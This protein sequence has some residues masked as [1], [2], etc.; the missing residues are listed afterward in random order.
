MTKELNFK[1]LNGNLLIVV[2]EVSNTT[3]SGLIKSETMI[4]EEEKKLDVYVSVAAIS[5][6]VKT[7]KVGD[8]VLLS[9]S[10]IKTIVIDEIR[11]GIVHIT[12]V[13]GIKY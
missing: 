3:K 4:K 6:E 5:D 13:A 8:K 11:Y 9:V 7:I 12:S 10:E 2:P 1:P